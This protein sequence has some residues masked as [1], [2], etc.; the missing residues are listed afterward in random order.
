MARY[1]DARCR[2]CRRLG[3]KLYLK[4]EKC[5]TPSA[6]SISGPTRPARAQ[7]RRRKVSDRGLQWR[8]KQKA[9]RGLRHPGEPVPQVLRGR[10][11]APGRHRRQ[12]CCARWSCGWTTWSTG[13]ASR[14]R[15]SRRGSSSLHGQLAV[16]GRKTTIPSRI[17]KLGRHRD[18]GRRR[19]REQRV[20]QES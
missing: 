8:E 15:G 12:R 20:L 11:A 13:W 14:T 19:G 10:G 4:G 6:L 16:N 17:L 5:F 7:T 3:E 1:T 2:L 18:A 9:A